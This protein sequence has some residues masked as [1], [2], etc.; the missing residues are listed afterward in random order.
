MVEDVCQV[1]GGGG[2]HDP[3]LTAAEPLDHF[4]SQSLGRCHWTWS[5]PADLE[6]LGDER[7]DGRVCPGTRWEPFLRVFEAGAGEP[8]AVGDIYGLHE[9]IA[10]ANGQSLPHRYGGARVGGVVEQERS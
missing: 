10:D 5:S 3:A 9:A 2:R 1:S 4:G 6:R 7:A 8:R